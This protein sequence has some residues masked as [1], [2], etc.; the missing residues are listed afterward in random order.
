M[1]DSFYVYSTI[2]CGLRGGLRR[3]WPCPGSCTGQC[4]SIPPEGSECLEVACVLE[5]TKRGWWKRWFSKSPGWI[6]SPGSNR[7]GS[8]HCIWS[9]ILNSI[10]SADSMQNCWM[11]FVL[12]HLILTT[13]LCWEVIITILLLEG[14]N[15]LPSNPQLELVISREQVWTSVSLL[16]PSVL[17]GVPLEGKKELVF[18]DLTP[19][20]YVAQSVAH[21]APSNHVNHDCLCWLTVFC[22]SFWK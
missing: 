4:P 11:L 9:F 6:K 20:K 17:Y 22:K 13:L 3:E 21:K 15:T 2:T 16:F 18:N 14:E 5:V 7:R 19:V 10:L 12:D 1:W 8:C